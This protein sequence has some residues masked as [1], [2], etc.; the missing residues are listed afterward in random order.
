MPVAEQR[1]L[2]QRSGDMCA[3]PDCRRALTAPRTDSDPVTSLGEIAHIVGESVNGPRGV[4]PL[5]SRERGLYENLILLCD[6]HHQLI[7]SHPATWTVSRLV[8]MKRTHEEWVRARL[9][10]IDPVTGTVGRGALAGGDDFLEWFIT[11]AERW[12]SVDSSIERALLGIHAALPLPPGSRGSLSAQLPEYVRRDLDVELRAAVSEANRRSA[13]VVVVGP[14]AAGKTRS[15]YEAVRAE[16]AGWRMIIPPT[17]GDLDELLLSGI[18]LDRSVIWLD[19]LTRHLDSGALSLRAVRRILAERNGP[20]LVIGTMW[21]KDFDRFCF[22]P[23]NGPVLDLNADATEILRLATRFDL[24]PDFTEAEHRRART[25]GERDPRVREAIERSAD[26]KIPSCLACAPELIR[27]WEHPSDPMGAAIITAAVEARLCGHPAVIPADLLRSL[28]AEY[29]T[30]AQR[31]AAA[32]DW[33][34]SALQWALRP[35]RGDVAPL[36][37]MARHVG[38]LD[39]YQA[40]DI[41]THHAEQRYR[42]RGQSPDKPWAVLAARADHEAFLV[43]GMFASACGHHDH[44]KAVWRRLAETGNTDAMTA[45]GLACQDDGDLEAAAIWFRRAVETG[46]N[47]AMAMLAATLQQLGRTSEAHN[48]LRRGAE[49]GVPGAMVGHGRVLEDDGDH[50]MA[51]H[52][53]EAASEAGDNGMGKLF[54]GC[55]LRDQGDLDAASERLLD[56]AE[57]GSSVAIIDPHNLAIPIGALD[58]E[59]GKYRK[60]ATTVF[61]GAACALGEI[62]LSQRRSEEAKTWLQRAAKLGQVDAM[63]LLGSTLA[64][65]GELELAV[66]WL[67]LAA[68]K[69]MVE[70]MFHVG[71]MLDDTEEAHEAGTWLR[72]VALEGHPQAM[73]RYG[74]YLHEH[75]DTAQALEWSTKARD[76]GDPAA[77]LFLAAVGEA[78]GQ[79]GVSVTPLEPCNLGDEVQWTPLAH[80]CGCVVDWGWEAERADPLA[81]M[82]WCSGMVTLECPWHAVARFAEHRPPLLVETSPRGPA[83]YAR[84]ASGVDVELGQRIALRIQQLLAMVESGDEAGIRESV[85][86]EYRTWLEAQQYDVVEESFRWCLVELVLNRHA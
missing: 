67:R 82:Q 64:D 4:S 86:P 16:L 33:F 38:E 19:E 46:D 20:L 12:P 77:G 2:F 81:F 70:A 76:A 9:G 18:P 85:P 39:G 43:V 56:A 1:K 5:T 21:L 13:F 14:S 27:R 74:I 7:D 51:R 31:A 6:Y 44:A 72:K 25:I 10:S 62:Y 40:S 3:F 41:L 34:D 69:G 17:A 30:S 24:V 26:A 22:P 47:E 61:T 73:G 55:L 54:L 37:P 71:V 80:A 42:T 29:L 50:Q 28:A 52:W 63:F 36:T 49:A 75:G 11:E 48:W 60:T 57:V 8:A 53:Y 79:L 32:D 83:F 35:V 66:T 78:E 68:E 23:D 84:A 45:L 58:V 15:V 59:I 65:E